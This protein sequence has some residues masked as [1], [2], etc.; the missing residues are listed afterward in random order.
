MIHKKK[1]SILYLFVGHFHYLKLNIFKNKTNMNII[2][3]IFGY[4]VTH[5]RW[6]NEVK[7]INKSQT[8]PED[9]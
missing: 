2:T 1:I 7:K 6:Y 3:W 4:A 8:V 9:K 5:F